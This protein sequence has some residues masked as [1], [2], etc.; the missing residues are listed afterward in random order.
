MDVK[1]KYRNGVIVPDEPLSLR[2]GAAVDIR[3]SD[4]EADAKFDAAPEPVPT[5]EEVKASF[6]AA[7]ANMSDDWRR[8]DAMLRAD[9]DADPEREAAAERARASTAA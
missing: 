4:E 3:V 6:K 9:R 2:E 7:A 1:G 8:I 5:L